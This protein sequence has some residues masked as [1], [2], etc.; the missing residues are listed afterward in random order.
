MSADVLSQNIHFRLIIHDY[1][2]KRHA[3]RCLNYSLADF[4]I[5][6][7]KTDTKSILHGVD[8]NVIDLWKILEDERHTSQV[9]DNLESYSRWAEDLVNDADLH[10]CNLDPVTKAMCQRETE[11]KKETWKLANSERCSGCRKDIW[12]WSKY[13]FYNFEWIELVLMLI[14][15][16]ASENPSFAIRSNLID[17]GWLNNLQQDF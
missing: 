12:Y 11:F 1:Y 4:L 14:C 8:P 13:A 10:T 6:K 2:S 3:R 16:Y 17:N 7:K 15:K 5:T 9:F